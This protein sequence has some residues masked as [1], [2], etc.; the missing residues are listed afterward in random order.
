MKN[1][2]GRL[3]KLERKPGPQGRHFYVWKNSE[4]H[5]QAEEQY[6]PGDMIHVISWLDRDSAV[7]GEG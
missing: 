3:S 5:R 1:F 2:D 7:D 4:A 6:Q